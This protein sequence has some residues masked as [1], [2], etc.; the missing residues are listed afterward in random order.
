MPFPADAHALIFEAATSVM[1]SAVR[2]RRPWK[3][4]FERRSALRIE[5]LMGWTED[6]D[7][8][9]QVE[10]SF[11]SADAAVGYARCQGLDYTVL[12]P[13]VHELHVASEIHAPEC[14]SPDDRQIG[15]A[16]SA[17][18]AAERDRKLAA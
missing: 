6:D 8:L 2:R 7:P 17:A 5:P 14:P 18:P 13:P 9:A 1:T 4:L 16:R 3:L 15:A 10:L 12:G 11:P